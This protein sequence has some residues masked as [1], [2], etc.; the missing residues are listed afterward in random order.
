MF[1][2]EQPLFFGSK[3]CERKLYIFFCAFKHIC[4]RKQTLEKGVKVD[5]DFYFAV[6]YKKI[7]ETATMNYIIEELEFFPR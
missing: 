6:L 3:K 7:S 4:L 2:V 5:T 1:E